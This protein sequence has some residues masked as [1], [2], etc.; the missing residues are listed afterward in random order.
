MGLPEA[1]RAFVVD[2]D[3]TQVAAGI[4]VMTIHAS[5]GLEFD[6]VFVDFPAVRR[7][8]SAEWKTAYVAVT[9]A[10]KELVITGSQNPVIDLALNLA[11]SK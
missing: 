7:F 3:A 2:D 1:L 5:K 9:R 4:R 8:T 11:E 10:Q 6:H